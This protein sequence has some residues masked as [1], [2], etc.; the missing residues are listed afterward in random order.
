MRYQNSRRTTDL[1]PDAG[2][3]AQISLMVSQ[4]HS[5]KVKIV[6]LRTDQ[7]G[8]IP[9]LRKAVEESFTRLVVDHPVHGRNWQVE[10]QTSNEHLEV[11]VPKQRTG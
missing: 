10:I 1:G 9:L 5:G 3:N 6:L 4:L 2:L 8:V 11:Y 7:L